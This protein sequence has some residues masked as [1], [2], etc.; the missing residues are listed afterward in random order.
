MQIVGCAYGFHSDEAEKAAPVV[1]PTVAAAVASAAAKPPTS[2]SEG[3]LPAAAPPKPPVAMAP[4]APKEVVIE[5]DPDDAIVEL[6]TKCRRNACAATYTSI[7][8][9]TNIC[10]H[11]PGV[12]VFHEASKYW[13]CCSPRAAEFDEFLRIGGCAEGK[14]KFLPF[15][16]E[17][18]E[19]NEVKCRFDFYQL[20]ENVIMNIYA[21]NVEHSKSSVAISATRI[22]AHVTFKDG[23]FFKKSFELAATI[24]PASSKFEILSTK[25]EIKLKKHDSS[26]S[27]T[28][29]ER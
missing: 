4:E 7:E 18:L 27:W 6:G 13:S 28:R 20:G 5:N 1:S 23:K 21:K 11:H 14:H 29:L 17:N 10:V 22:D 12:A 2:S 9:K 15:K 24:D 16:A 3:S 25:I 26:I 19:A 8:S